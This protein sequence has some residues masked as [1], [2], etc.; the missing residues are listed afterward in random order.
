LT[1]TEQPKINI[2]GLIIGDGMVDPKSSLSQLGITAFT[3][4]LIDFYERKQLEGYI[5]EGLRNI[6]LQKY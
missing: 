6:D 4:G 2:K 1:A 3:L 5:L